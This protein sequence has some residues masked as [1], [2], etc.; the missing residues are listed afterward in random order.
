MVNILFN[1]SARS[2]ANHVNRTGRKADDSLMRLATGRRVVNFG[3]DTASSAIASNIGVEILSLGKASLNATQATSM[4]RT[5]DATLAWDNEVMMQIESLA[6]QAASGHITPSERSMLDQEFQALKQEINRVALTSG[7][8]QINLL[9]GAKSTQAATP[10]ATAVD[11]NV[12]L[13]G[14]NPQ[15]QPIQGV[16]YQFDNSVE[17]S[18]F[19]I[20]YN[21]S[22]QDCNTGGKFSV[23]DI[24][25]GISEAVSIS[26]PNNSEISNKYRIGD[27]GL[28]ISIDS[29]FNA[30]N[31]FAYS[32]NTVDNAGVGKYLP[33]GSSLVNDNIRI[34]QMQG[35]IDD[36][37]SVTAAD[38]LS[39]V[40]AMD[41]ISFSPDGSSTPDPTNAVF[42]LPVKSPGN[43][44]FVSQSLD[45]T[46]IG[47]KTINL[48]RQREENGQTFTDS[49]A[50]EVV[51]TEPF[52]ADDLQLG[53]AKSSTRIVLG[54]IKNLI[55]AEPCSSADSEN[56][57]SFLIG[58]GGSGSIEDNTFSFQLTPVTSQ[59]LGLD[60]LRVDTQHNAQN[61]LVGIHAGLDMLDTVRERVGASQKIIGMISSSIEIEIENN[62]AAVAALTAVDFAKEVSELS[63]TTIVVQAGYS[64]LNRSV[65]LAEN[66]LIL[67]RA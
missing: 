19:E 6:V 54:Q 62:E 31:K 18:A 2:I 47:R 35:K 3:D 65:Q 66:A 61:A 25:T 53:V 26:V 17:A 44:S 55:V 49:I 39:T 34:V 13:G 43:A 24:N 45:L 27:L 57:F 21:A 10:M 56:K 64:A 4:L 15:G 38:G 60:A 14:L 51:V 28:T 30:G 52:T 37:I 41:T 58:S 40:Y 32:V 59:S 63:N 67:L 48:S 5:A 42:S 9:S 8:N 1:E 16:T 20:T 29:T 50:V 12:A 46:T 23:R 36:V 22:A 33:N 11:S 7:F